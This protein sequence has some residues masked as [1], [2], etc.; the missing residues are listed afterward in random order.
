MQ[1]KKEEHLEEKYPN[2][3]NSVKE[4]WY[5]NYVPR[6]GD[7][8]FDIG[9]G[10]GEDSIPFSYHVGNEG[11][12]ISI[13]ANPKSFTFLKSECEVNNLKNII[14]LN[15]AITDLNQDVYIEDN[16]DWIS[17]ALSDHK[18]NGIKIKGNTLDSICSKLNI[19]K[20]NFL[21]MNIEGAELEAIKGMTESIKIIEKICICCHDFRTERGEDKKFKTKKMIIEFLQKNNFSILIRSNDHRDYVRDHIFGSKI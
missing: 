7:I 5:I 19:N 20:I 21:K 12:V 6:S 17:N 14:P 10:Q 13:E 11:K 18:N 9:A 1:I 4:Y 3:F 15:I 8:I 2:Y 16:G